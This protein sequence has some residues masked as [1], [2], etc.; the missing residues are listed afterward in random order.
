M[1]ASMR[2]QRATKVS[3]GAIA[4][5]D[6]ERRRDR[7]RPAGAESALDA[8]TCAMMEQRLGHDLRHVRI[9]TDAAAAESADAL[10]TRAYT[11]GGHIVFGHGAYAPETSDGQRL[12]AHELTHVLQQT[13]SPG[14]MAS[15]VRAEAEA[16]AQSARVVARQAGGSLSAAPAGTIQFEEKSKASGSGERTGTKEGK[17]TFGFKA[18]VTVPV[19]SDLSFG[20]VSFLDDLKLSGTGG[21]TGDALGSSAAELDDLK[22]QLAL[23]LAKLELV[24]TKDK[25]EALRQG[26]FS[27]GATLS[28]TG[29]QTF[30]FDPLDPTTSLGASLALK[31]TAVSP[32]LLPGRMGQ[33]TLSSSLST[34]GS[35]SQDMAAEGK[36]S[37][38]LEG[39]V[40]SEAAFKSVPSRRP[41]MT[42]LGALG[43]EA[44]VTAG[45]EAG[46]SGTVTPEKTSG[47][48]SASGSL[49]LAGKEKGIERFIKLQVT[50][51]ISVDRA[52]GK[53]AATTKSLFL[54][55]SAGFK[56]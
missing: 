55:V 15:P 53:A 23:T 14:P 46:V 2:P 17:D 38:K 36:T 10:D 24:S 4:S 25:A 8:T 21:V 27:L 26:K 31:H 37:P 42:L 9:H 6:P 20:S 56:F 39:K 41:A 22:L 49:G 28:A 18:D 34:T 45:L 33:L 52:A 29:T 5:P 35:F 30:A 13:A 1:Y 11:V 51:D 3:S 48:A 12:L 44:Q 47:K 32:S 16:E 54:G 43:T 7:R 19:T 40:G 50:G